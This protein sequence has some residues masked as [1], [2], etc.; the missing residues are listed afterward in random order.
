MRVSIEYFVTVALAELSLSV[1]AAKNEGAQIADG[2]SD[3]K[4]GCGKPVL[5]SS[6]RFEFE[7]PRLTVSRS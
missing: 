7:K 4:V 3:I 6:R 2:S 1:D 5:Y